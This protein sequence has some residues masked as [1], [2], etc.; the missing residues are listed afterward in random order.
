MNSRFLRE[1]LKW[2]LYPFTLPI[3]AG[4][5]VGY[6]WIPSS[7]SRFLRGIYEPE[8]TEA[9]CKIVARG[10]IVLDI[11]AH[12]G[13]FS[14]LMSSLVGPTGKIFSFEPRGINYTFLKKHLSKNNCSNVHVIKAAVGNTIGT[15]YMDTR[16]GTGTGKL[17]EAGNLA[18]KI[19]SV[20]GFYREFPQYP[21]PSFMKIDVE[22][23]EFEVLKGAEH[24]IRKFKPRIVLATHSR[25]LDLECSQWLTLIGYQSEAIQQLIGDKETIYIHSTK[26]GEKCL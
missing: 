4:P 15:A 9:L 10:D 8:K 21:P 6:K 2:S 7:G 5:L 25:Q 3:K 12:V 1:L 22:G 13:Y 24:T 16:T 17:H 23:A 18:V 14:V 19:I 11:G 20:D 26:K